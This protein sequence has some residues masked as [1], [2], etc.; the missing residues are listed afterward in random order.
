MS[1]V[2]GLGCAAPSATVRARAKGR[3]R[4]DKNAGERR[5]PRLPAHSGGARQPHAPAAVPCQRLDPGRWALTIRCPC[6]RGGICGW[7]FSCDGRA[8]FSQMSSCAEA[9][10]FLGNCPGTRMDGNNDDVPC[11]Q[12]W[13]KLWSNAVAAWCRVPAPHSTGGQGACRSGPSGSGLWAAE[14]DAA[15]APGGLDLPHRSFEARGM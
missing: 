1:G 3:R 10:Y 12:Q 5:C 4:Q 6:R 11:E 9:T 7:A 13:C 8:Q 2:K 15:A 14:P